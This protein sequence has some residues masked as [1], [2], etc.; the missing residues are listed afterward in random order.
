MRLLKALLIVGAALSLIVVPALAQDEGTLG[1]GEGAP[2]VETNFGGD[3]ATLNPIL[4][5]DGSSQDVADWLFPDLLAGDPDTGLPVKAGPGSLALDWTVSDDGTVYTFTLRSDAVWSD[6]TPITAAD[7]KYAYDAIV[8][9]EID[10]RLTSSVENV[11]SVEAPDATTLIVTFKTA[12]CSALFTANFVPIVPSA[13]YQE[14]YPTLADMT[15]DSEYNLAPEVTWGPFKFANFR[16]GEQVTLLADQSYPDAQL[17]YV[18]PEGWVYKQVADQIVAVEQFLA[19]EVTLIDSVPDDRNQ[20]LADLGAAGEV[21]YRVAPSASWHYIY[22]NLSDPLNPVDGADA[23]GNPIDQG[24]HPIFGDKRVRQAYAM[25]IDHEALKAGAFNGDGNPIGSF[26]LP[27]SWAFDGEAA[28]PWPF[29]LEAAAKLLDEAGFVDDDN[30]PSTPRVATEDALYAEAGTPLEFSLT[31]F[32]GNPTIDATSVLIQDQLSRSGF[33]MNLDIIEFQ[34]ML[35]KLLNQSFD[36]LMVFIG[37]F[38][39]NDPNGALEILD[40][41]GDIV[42]SGVNAGSFYNERF[43]EIMKEARSLPGCDPDA[44]N[45]LY[46]EAQAIIREEL[47]VY[48]VTNSTVPYVA[49]ADVVNYDPR[50]SSIRWN[51][52]TWSQ[53][54][55]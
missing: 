20:Q 28:P 18:V 46:S 13:K 5:A 12:D 17:G 19:G 34:A 31:T 39:P 6:G 25:S 43:S 37:P 48:F 42:G 11:A 41:S 55:R 10:S 4:I 15:T 40:P 1:P 32:S 23:D 30:D 27:Q 51:I 7:Y 22:F 26:M 21:D 24:H 9:G 2:V 3:I 53:A 8:S 54:P 38:D 29:D 36:T 35:D 52:T 44:R 47:P 45:V 49:Q 50:A 14:V 16:P 33:K